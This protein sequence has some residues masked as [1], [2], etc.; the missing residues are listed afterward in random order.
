M[1]PNRLILLLFSSLFLLNSCEKQTGMDF[2]QNKWKVQSVV[3]DDK[4]FTVP[5]ERTF[6]R[7]EAYILKFVNDTDFTMNTSVNYAGGS[8]QIVSEGHIV[9]NY[10]EGTMV[11]ASGY[12]KEFNE[13][14]VSVFN[15]VMSYSYTKNKL[16]FRGEKNK[17][18]VF[19]KQK[20]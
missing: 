14:L 6:L 20:K 11:G 13:Q 17:E 2:L 15:G 1:K 16:I 9:I 19:V 3:N 8:Y 7:E 12:Q 5:S 4:R 10:G 18:A